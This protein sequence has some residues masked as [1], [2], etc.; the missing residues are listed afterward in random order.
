MPNT[1]SQKGKR[2][3]FDVIVI[4][5]GVAGLS[6]ILELSKSKP[7][8]RIA[9]ITKKTLQESNSYYAQGGIAAAKQDAASIAGHVADTHAAGDE[10][11]NSAAVEAI[12]QQAPNSI[13][14]LLDQ[15]VNFDRNKNKQFDRGQ[16][17][18]H[19]ERRIYHSGD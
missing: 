14:Y 11:C 8:T 13:Q 1:I 12:L 19:S 3:N 10:F 2:Y 15:G 16:E 6:Y 7:K 9:L 17:G 18:G 4:G 5:S